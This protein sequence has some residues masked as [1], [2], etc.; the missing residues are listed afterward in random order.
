MAIR[1]RNLTPGSMLEGMYK[2]LR[3]ECRVEDAGGK[4]AFVLEDDRRFKSPSAA[5]S[6]VM[7]GKAPYDLVQWSG[8]K[9]LLDRFVGLFEL[10]PKAPV[11]GIEAGAAS[12]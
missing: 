6:A 1:D 9:A 4:L 12:A 5:A 11:P 8:D 2:K 3:Y 7:Y 10:P